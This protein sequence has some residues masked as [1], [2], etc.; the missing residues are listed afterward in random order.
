MF[1]HKINRGEFDFIMDHQIYSLKHLYWELALVLNKQ[2]ADYDI[3]SY[4][5]YKL[6]EEDLLKKIYLEKN[7]SF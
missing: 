4:S 7:G 3:I 5:I 1:F 6:A 2:C